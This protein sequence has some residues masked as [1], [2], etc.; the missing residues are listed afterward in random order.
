M[1]STTWSGWINANGAGGWQVIFGME[2]GT[3]DRFLM[4]KSGS[5]KFCMGHTSGCWEPGPSITPGVW[6]H[7][8]SIYDN[9]AMRFYLKGAEYTQPILMRGIIHQMAHLQL[10]LIKMV[11]KTSIKDS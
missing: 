10:G 11:V 9:G 1:P 6:Q 7:V 4:V 3:W 5:T 2:D 8:V